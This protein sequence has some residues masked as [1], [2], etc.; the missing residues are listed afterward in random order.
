MPLFQLDEHDVTFPAPHLALK[1]PSGLLAI[2][3]D[4]SSAR[5]KEAYQT[6]IFPWYT[7]HETPLWWSP[8]PRAVLP[9]GTLHIGRTLRKFLRQAPYTI[10]LNQAFSDVIE[11]CSVRDE[12]TWIG[13]DIKTGYRALH[14][15]GAAHSVEVWEGNELV[16]GLYGVNV[17]AV[18]CGESMFSR[19]N[20]ASKCAFVA[21]YNHFLRYGGQLF[22]CQV[23]NSHTA[24]LG[25]IEIARDHYL[26][27]LSRWKKVIIDKKCWYQQSLE[28]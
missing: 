15:Q 21:F 17:G 25:A 27:A 6:G 19:R 13:P 12:G 7:P 11:A 16:G 14:Q 5:L 28:L 3:G 10:T 20:N 4:I 24:A 8:D 22:D 2:G 26:E 18:F 9:A 23:L 1:E